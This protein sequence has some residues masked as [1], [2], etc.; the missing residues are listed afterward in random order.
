MKNKFNY[1]FIIGCEGTGHH[2]F[3]HCDLNPKDSVELH[4]LIM[5]YF[6]TNTTP[7]QQKELKKNIYEI[8]KNNIGVVCKESASFPY[9]RPTNPLMSHDILGFYEL[10]NE[11]EHVNLFFV[12]LTRNIVFSTLCSANRFDRDKSILFT[13]RLQEN[14]LNYINSQIQLIPKDKYIIVEI[15]NIQKNIEEFI[16]IIQ[17]KSKMKISCDYDDIKISD[18]SK[19][20]TD[21]NYDYLVNY[22]NKN[23]LKQFNFLKE[24]THLIS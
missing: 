10:F 20:L 12:V 11:M 23:R 3:N 6:N 13:S 1:I 17:E 19:Y 8:T 5:T 2:L 7:T 15:S 18:D 21:K 22:F 9:G 16:K 24:N 4:N 14:C